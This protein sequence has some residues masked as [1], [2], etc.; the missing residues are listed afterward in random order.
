MKKR[1][2]VSVISF[3]ALIAIAAIGYFNLVTYETTPSSSK[4]FAT[5]DPLFRVQLNSGWEVL[6]APDDGGAYAACGFAYS[7]SE[8]GGKSWTPQFIGRDETLKCSVKI[9]R[10]KRVCVVCLLP[11]DDGPFCSAVLTRD[12]V[13]RN[14]AL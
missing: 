2:T 3:I 13:D 4:R 11:V 1:R 8:L 7:S 6:S 5:I 9:P 10:G 14:S 12:L